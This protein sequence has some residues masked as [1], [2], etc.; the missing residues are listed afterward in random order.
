MIVELCEKGTP[1]FNAIAVINALQRES[2]A[3][4][5]QEILQRCKDNEDFRKLLY[6]ALNKSS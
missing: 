3:L 1:M 6:Y 5:K 2:S 4:K